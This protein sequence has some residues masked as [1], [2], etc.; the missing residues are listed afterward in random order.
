M[1]RNVFLLL[2]LFCSS[3]VS[4]FA[5]TFTADT[6]LVSN[7]TDKQRNAFYTKNPPPVLAVYQKEEKT[8]VVL[9]AKHSPQ[10]IPSVQYAFEQYQPQ[11]ALVEREPGAPFMPCTSGEDGYT[12]ALSARNNIPLVRSDL[13]LEHQWKETQKRGFSYEDFQMLWII[14][15]AYGLAKQEKQQANAATEI[16]DYER[17]IHNPAWGELFTQDSLL[18]YFQQ[19]YHKDFNTTNFIELYQNLMNR[20]PQ[21]WVRKTPFYQIMHLN[22]DIRSVFMLE[23]IAAALNEYNVVFSEMGASHFIEI[24]KALKKMM[25]KPLYI[26]ADQIPAQQIWQNCTLNGLQEKVLVAD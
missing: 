11:I 22:P 25:G 23:N 20:Y 16:K 7:P 21:K 17:T 24:S 8:L 15:S 2:S 4:V 1:K 3:C 18:A 12:A 19:H 10:S 5:Q 26:Q 13:D 6:A 9:A 14:R